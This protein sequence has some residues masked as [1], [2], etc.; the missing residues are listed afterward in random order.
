MGVPM[1]L[2]QVADNQRAVIEPLVAGGVAKRLDREVAQDEAALEAAIEGFIRT[3]PAELRRMSEAGRRLV[4][5]RGAAR[6]ARVLGEL[7]R[8]KSQGEAS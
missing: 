4:D 1:L 5:G 3:D 8:A 2:V 7:A 6:I